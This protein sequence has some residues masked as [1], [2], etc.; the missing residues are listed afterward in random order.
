MTRFQVPDTAED[1]RRARR[2]PVVAALFIA[3]LAFA[4][5]AFYSGA[6]DAPPSVAVVASR[7]V[8]PIVPD[9]IPF[10]ANFA[11][12]KEAEDARD[13]DGDPERDPHYYDVGVQR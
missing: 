6:N 10:S 13:N 12:D 8:T 1:R 2:A 5:R 9:Q 11:R 4:G 7:V 3:A